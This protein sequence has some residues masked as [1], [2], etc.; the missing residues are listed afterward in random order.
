MKRYVRFNHADQAGYGLVENGVVRLVD[1]DIFGDHTVTG[2]AYP[3]E[4]VKLLSPCQP[5][6]IICIGLNY[7]D[8]ARELNMPL[9]QEP[10]MFLK[11]LTAILSPGE[12]I[13]YPRMTERLEYEGELGVVIGKGGKDI[14][15]ERATEHIFGYTVANDVTARDL[16]KKDGQWTRS[17][18][19]DTFCPFGPYLV[20][21]VDGSSLKIET[22]LNGEVK[23][24][25]NTSN[26]IFGVPFL[27]S[28]ISQVM[29][30]EAGDLILTGTPFGVGPM[31]AGD[32]VEVEIE[33]LGV[34]MNTV[35][36]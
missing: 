7:I 29:T 12:A 14:P 4:R 27:V 17:K 34:L 3:L 6:K 33:H 23:Q 18:S 5:S 16:Q 22:R 2:Q 9:P 26:L 21:G 1:G 10:V 24:S 19:F 28:F 15:L 25:S 36:K 31:Q 20:T 8:H 11:P 35:S 13:V 30:L 32:V